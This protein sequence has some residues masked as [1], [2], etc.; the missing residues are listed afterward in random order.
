MLNQFGRQ[1]RQSIVLAL[2]PAIF[3]LDVWPS[4]YP[5]SFSPWRNAR[6]RIVYASGDALLRNPITFIAGCC[7]RRDRPPSRRATEKRDEL[8][9]FHSITSSAL[10]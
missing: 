10:H 9:A 3:D 2:R 1:H 7:A 8:A 5:A 6:R 4:T